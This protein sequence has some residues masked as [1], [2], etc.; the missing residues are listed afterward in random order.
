[1][2]IF[3][4]KTFSTHHLNCCLLCRITPSVSM[5]SPGVSQWTVNENSFDGQMTQTDWNITH[6]DSLDSCRDYSMGEQKGIDLILLLLSSST[7]L[8]YRAGSKYSTQFGKHF[9]SRSLAR[10]RRC[11]CRHHDG[12]KLS[13]SMHHTPQVTFA[14]PNRNKTRS[15]LPDLRSV[16]TC[17]CGRNHD[18]RNSTSFGL[19]DSYGSTESLIDEAENFLCKSI[20]GVFVRDE[21]TTP[22]T[23]LAVNRRCSENDIKRGNGSFCL[24]HLENDDV[25]LTV[26]LFVDYSP[27]KQTLPFLPKSPQCLKPGHLAKVIGKNGRCVI[28]RIRYIG[29]LAST[30]TGPNGNYQKDAETFIGLQLPNKIGDCDGSFENRR[31]FDW[32]AANTLLINVF[33]FFCVSLQ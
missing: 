4:T 29:P 16:C 10:C 19:G 21:K 7:F 20:D 24:N 5:T 17:G 32:Y 14:E 28:G 22:K 18:A 30:G 33:L 23:M 2:F 3:D 26:V 31:F 15:S 11:R 8:I 13:E 1:M 6:G 25:I 27:S 12:L 9:R